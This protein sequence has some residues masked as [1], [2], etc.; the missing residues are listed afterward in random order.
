MLSA[1]M[2]QSMYE[3]DTD[4]SKHRQNALAELLDTEKGFVTSAPSAP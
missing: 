4:S 2:Q 3:P 1:V